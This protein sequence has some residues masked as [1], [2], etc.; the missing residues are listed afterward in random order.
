M[1]DLQNSNI[2]RID[3]LGRVVVPKDI[4]KKLHIKD[5]EPLEIY[6]ENNEIHIRKY[7]SLPDIIEFI[8]YLVDIGHR[9]TGN[10]FIITDRE[11]IIASNV[12]EYLNLSLND[13]LESLVLN[14]R[15]LKNEKIEL[16]IKS[17]I[18][19]TGYFNIYP[20]IIDNDRSGVIIEFSSNALQNDFVVK[21]FKNL[22]ENKLSNY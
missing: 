9:I 3:E 16:E 19:L 12:S 7:S 8:R 18:K 20:I 13:K 4:R 17:D 5:N 15:E 14:S 6:I 2:R 21:I 10:T 1:I 11:H 22:L